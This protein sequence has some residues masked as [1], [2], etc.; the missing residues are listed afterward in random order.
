MVRSSMELQSGVEF[1]GRFHVVRR[2]GG[3]GFGPVYE[4]REIT[5]VAP[6][7]LKVLHPEHL[8]HP[9]LR[10]RFE[11]EAPIARSI[12]RAQVV[13][14]LDAGGTVVLS[15]PPRAPQAARGHDPSRARLLRLRREAQGA[16]R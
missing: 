13:T 8:A 6:M 12:P 1:A 2:L 5:G 7:A 15:E 9:T 14:V 3:G 4:A 16:A 10:E 11:M